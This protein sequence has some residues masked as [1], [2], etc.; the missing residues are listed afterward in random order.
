MSGAVATTT[1]S[2]TSCPPSD[3]QPVHAAPSAVSRYHRAPSSPRTNA[4]TRRSRY[5]T[6]AGC[7]VATPPNDAHGPQPPAYDR[8]H[9]ASSI[10]RA[11]RYNPGGSAADATLDDQTP[12]N[13]ET[14]TP[15]ATINLHTAR[16]PAPR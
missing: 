15:S 11:K 14:A 3:R 8:Y 9:N 7:P 12:P 5:R 2:P 6:D 4:P 1:G 10:P 16:M 13:A